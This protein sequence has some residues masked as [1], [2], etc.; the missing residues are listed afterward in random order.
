MTPS[1][2][3]YLGPDPLSHQPSDLAGFGVPAE[4]RL[5]EDQFPVQRNLEP[6]LRGRQEGD[7]RDDRSPSTQQF[8]RQT[9]GARDVVSGDAEFDEE[10]VPR[11]QHESLSSSQSPPV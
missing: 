4:L 8:V 5:R 6:P 11:I 1:T 2:A 7:V 9:D 10:P 3:G